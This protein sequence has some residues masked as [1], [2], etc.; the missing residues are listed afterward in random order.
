[1]ISDNFKSIKTAL[2]IVFGAL[3]FIMMIIFAAALL[4]MDED[5]DNAARCESLGGVE[6]S[7]GKCFVN[8]EEI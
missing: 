7:D 5:L 4:G 2:A 1:M 3:L 6:G 8:G